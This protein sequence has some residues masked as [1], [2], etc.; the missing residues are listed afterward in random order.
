MQF[1]RCAFAFG[2]LLPTSGMLT[3]EPSQGLVGLSVRLYGVFCCKERNLL[4]SNPYSISLLRG[5]IGRRY[6]DG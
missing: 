1:P 6:G 3:K 5:G 2:K 4:T